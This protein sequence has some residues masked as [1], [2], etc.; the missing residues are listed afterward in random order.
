[1]G[2]TARNSFDKPYDCLKDWPEDCFVQCG[3]DGIVFEEG[4]LEETFKSEDGL[5]KTIATVIGSPTEKKHYRTA[6]FEAFPK[7]PSCFIRGE[8]TTIQE[9]E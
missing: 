6:F 3:G 1:M 9:A 2:K 5:L 7:K 4:S 8:G